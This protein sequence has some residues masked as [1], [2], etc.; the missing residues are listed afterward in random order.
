MRIDAHQHFWKYNPVRDSWISDTMQAIQRDFLPNDLHTILRGNAIQG[1]IAVQ[2]DE[3][4]E[5]T[6]FL[7][8]L[9]DE[10]DFIK[11]VVGWLDFF[12]NDFDEKLAYYS[13]DKSLKG[14]RH[15]LQGKPEGFFFKKKF[16]QSL[17]KLER[18]NL[19]YDLLV[20]ENQLPEVIELVKQFPKQRFVL[21]H[22]GK[23]KIS[24]GLDANWVDNITQLSKHENV[25]CKISGMV[26]ET[27]NCKWTTSEFYPFMDVIVDAF[28]V[29][30]ILYGSDWPVCFLA[31]EYEQVLAIVTSYFQ[32][33]SGQEINKVMGGNAIQFYNISS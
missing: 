16:K 33:Y 24:L 30:R 12:D 31:A 9:A 3:S 18:Y 26:T 15:I 4:E 25:Y 11:G 6:D 28:G 7:L 2:A 21:D 17:A 8:R 5:E 19:T 29:D 13:K 27:E 10:N 23:P 14:V 22:I 1:C 32:N 20:F